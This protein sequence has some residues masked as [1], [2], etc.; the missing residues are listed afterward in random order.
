MPGAVAALAGAFDAGTAL[1]IA[2][3]ALPLWA[4]SITFLLLHSLLQTELTLPHSAPSF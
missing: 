3:P 1:E 4:S 2:A